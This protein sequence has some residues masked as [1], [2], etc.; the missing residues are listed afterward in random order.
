ML[1]RRKSSSGSTPPSRRCSSVSDI[2]PLDCSMEQAAS[3]QQD[4]VM[5]ME[6]VN[7]SVLERIRNILRFDAIN[8]ESTAVRN[9]KMLSLSEDQN[10][11]SYI[12]H[13]GVDVCFTD[14]YHSSP[15]QLEQYR[16]IG[17][18]EVDT[19]LS[20]FKSFGPFDD[21]ISAAA[22]ARDNL[23]SNVT[24]NRLAQFYRHYEKIPSWVDFDQIQRGI[25]VFLA[26]LPAAGCA[27]YYRSLV[28]GFS[29]PKIVEVLKSTRYLVSDRQKTLYR[30]IDTGGLLAACFAPTESR[31]SA[32]SL[33]PGCRGWLA[34]L[35]V[36]VLHAKIRRR[37]LQMKRRDDDGHSVQ[38]WDIE[39]NGIPINQED[40]AATLLAFSVNV[41][42]GIEIIAGKPLSANEQHDYLA[43]WRYLGWLLGIDTPESDHMSSNCDKAMQES[44]PPIDP[45]GPSILHAYASLESII[46]HILHPEPSSCDLVT[47]LLSV[48]GFFA[49][50][51]EVCRILIGGPLADGLGLPKYH[52]WQ[53]WTVEALRIFVANF[54]LKVTVYTFLMCFRFYTLLTMSSPWFKAKTTVWHGDLQRKFLH[55]W[56]E[57]HSSRMS[58]AYKKDKTAAS[59]KKS[60]SCPFSMVMPPQL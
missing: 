13:Y 37:L 21:V 28:G 25:D 57:G 35:R 17:D 33:R 59:A 19:L 18:P 7:I 48:R 27:L 41:L 51:A 44:L 31:L 56:E 26:Y 3:G 46:L 6:F 43:L 24:T 54:L 49:F 11:I 36:R 52:C 38:L 40:L 5:V 14:E 23:K 58:A 53:G 55:K 8:L 39:R 10:S 29:I 42:I 30:L 4:E 1:Y 20:E 34:A 22:V 45:C 47:H 15:S 32:A 16:K 2:S 9:S 50:R 12:H 60:S